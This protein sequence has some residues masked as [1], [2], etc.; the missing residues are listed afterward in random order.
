ML[1][2]MAHIPLAAGALGTKP[3]AHAAGRGLPSLSGLRTWL[4]TLVAGQ[5][6]KASNRIKIALL[7]M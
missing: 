4:K 1:C 3:A 2:A 6:D 5:D 7:D